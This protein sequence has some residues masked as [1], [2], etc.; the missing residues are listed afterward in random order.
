MKRDIRGLN[1]LQINLRHHSVDINGTSEAVEKA[2]VEINGVIDHLREMQNCEHI[3]NE[4]HQ[5]AICFMETED[6]EM[7]RLESCGHPFCKTCI[8]SQLESAVGNSD[9]PLS[10]CK[11]GC[12]ELWSWKDITKLSLQS[13]MTI[14]NL[15]NR[16]TSSYIARNSKKYKYCTS[17][18]CPSVYRVTNMA[19][20]FSCGECGVRICTACHIQYH[21]GISCDT[22]KEL[23][24]DT[25]GIAIWLRKDPHNRKLCP[26]CGLPIEKSSG[27]DHM[28]CTKCRR[29]FCWVCLAH[30]SSSGDCYGHLRREH[31]RYGGGY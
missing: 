26:G 16:A 18:E 8:V 28:E 14:N 27:C 13:G 7:Y 24:E 20:E 9:F 22:M 12:D 25:S 11:E 23:K 2:V 4:E 3:E 29:H 10:C 6:G 5:C 15:V 30:F 21:D 31:G 19:N 17:P 1:R